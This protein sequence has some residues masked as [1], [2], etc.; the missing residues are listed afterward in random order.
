MEPCHDDHQRL[1]IEGLTRMSCAQVLEANV[2]NPYDPAHSLAFHPGSWTL[3]PHDLPPRALV[4]RPLDMDSVT[5]SLKVLDAFGGV[6]QC[7]RP[8]NRSRTGEACIPRSTKLYSSREDPDGVEALTLFNPDIKK[9]RREAGHAFDFGPSQFVGSCGSNLSNHL[10]YLYCATHLDQVAFDKLFRCFRYALS[11]AAA[12]ELGGHLAVDCTGGQPPVYTGLAEEEGDEPLGG[13]MF[14]PKFYRRVAAGTAFP[15][16][17][18]EQLDRVAQAMRSEDLPR[19]VLGEDWRQQHGGALARAWP[20]HMRLVFTTYWMRHTLRP[21]SA[22]PQQGPH[23]D[24]PASWHPQASAKAK[25]LLQDLFNLDVPFP[26][27]ALGGIWIGSNLSLVAQAPPQP[28]GTVSP[29]VVQGLELEPQEGREGEFPFTHPDLLAPG[30]TVLLCPKTIQ[31]A[32]PKSNA[33]SFLGSHRLG[34]GLEFGTTQHLLNRRTTGTGEPWRQSWMS[35]AM[36]YHGHHLPGIIYNGLPAHSKMNGPRIS[37]KQVDSAKR[38]LTVIGV[39]VWLL[40][41][42]WTGWGGV[43]PLHPPPT[44]PAHPSQPLPIPPP[45]LQL[46]IQDRTSRPA[47]LAKARQSLL[48]LLDIPMRELRRWGGASNPLRVEV[49][50]PLSSRGPG[51]SSLQAMTADILLE[52]NARVQGLDCTP[53]RWAPWNDVRLLFYAWHHELREQARA[54]LAHPPNSLTPPTTD[55]LLYGPF[56]WTLLCDG[57]RFKVDDNDL[58]KDLSKRAMTHGLTRLDTEVLDAM[59]RPGLEPPRDPVQAFL[60]HLDPML[61][62]MSMSLPVVAQA[63]SV[64]AEHL[65]RGVSLGAWGIGFV[66]AGE[67]LVGTGCGWGLWCACPSPLAVDCCWLWVCVWGDCD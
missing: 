53:L 34:S 29:L 17:T 2:A 5:V 26:E 54:M 22:T 9:R 45:P 42:C 24:D 64:A 31:R 43:E 66:L 18:P 63:Y 46:A 57:K 65:I 27:D 16:M 40:G 50:Y 36:P 12:Y 61:S 4:N 3:A 58:W 1:A 47:A 11:G 15:V 8:L 44:H 10:A 51:G 39:W 49:G 60:D 35:L 20:Q 59:L 55:A 25:V 67:G 14:D 33:Y 28:G 52:A 56:L 32:F 41:C 48:D 23:P 62:G 30:G 37:R 38:D 21:Y 19:H 7:F 13:A 6:L